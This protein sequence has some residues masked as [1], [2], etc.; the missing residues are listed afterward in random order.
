[1]PAVSHGRSSQV[2]SVH[3]PA[4][5]HSSLAIVH[6]SSGYSEYVLTET[7]QVVGVEDEGVVSLYQGLVGCDYKGSEDSTG[8]AVFWKGWESRMKFIG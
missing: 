7:G 8:Q 3:R 6:R 1:M 5:L 4:N 2:L